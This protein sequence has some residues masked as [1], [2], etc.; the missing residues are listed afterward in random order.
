M[1]LP[2]LG[3][4]ALHVDNSGTLSLLHLGKRLFSGKTLAGG[5]KEYRQSTGN[6]A[7]RKW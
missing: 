4:K 1:Y 5:I 3:G 6:N 7:R 2:V